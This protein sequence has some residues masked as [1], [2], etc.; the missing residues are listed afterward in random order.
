MSV[1][2]NCALSKKDSNTKS[3][4]TMA[5]TASIYSTLAFN[6]FIFIL[7]LVIFEF[8]RTR[9]IDIYAPRS[10]GSK[11]TSPPAK[12][13]PFAW[14]Y[15]VY[16]LTDDDMLRLAG[17]DG[18]VMLRFLSFCTHLS[19]YCSAGAIVLMPIYFYADGA[20]DSSGIDRVSMANIVPKGTRLWAAFVFA[21]IFNAVF[22]RLI[23]QEY[24]IFMAARNKFFLGCDLDIPAQM[25]F[26]V[27]VEN[28][29]P[30]FRTSR[31]LKE[32][33]N[34]IFPDEVL[35]ATV[36]VTTPELDRV[37][38]ERAALVREIEEAV[39]ECEASH[40]KNRPV[41]HLVDGKISYVFF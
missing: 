12:K 17:M 6:G 26:T 39:G 11:P 41:L 13:S 30:E 1:N 29:P 18:F 20:D 35:F 16:F 33:F 32:F 5:D 27:Q 9:V 24:A 7:L 14:I 23:H 22:L 37:V 25:N 3:A 4:R 34:R 19:A 15:D 36:E 31:R 8:L 2:S 38:A 40:G 28:I 21:Y 10:R